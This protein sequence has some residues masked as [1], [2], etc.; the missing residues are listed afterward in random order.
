MEYNNKVDKYRVEQES[1]EKKK[2]GE[3]MIHDFNFLCNC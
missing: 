2:K 3:H 1:A